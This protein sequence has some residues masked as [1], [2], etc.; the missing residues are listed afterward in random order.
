VAARPIT[1][2]LAV[3]VAGFLV[4]LAA[5]ALA[6]AP[7]GSAVSVMGYT[8]ANGA[9]VTTR[10]PSF[11]IQISGMKPQYFAVWVST[12]SATDGG[13]FVGFNDVIPACVLSYDKSTLT[14]GLNSYDEL[15]PG[16]WYWQ[17]E[18]FDDGCNM[19][20]T[21]NGP[22]TC[23]PGL[24]TTCS[25]DGDC[26]GPA[27]SFTIPSSTGSAHPLVPS[28]PPV[29]TTPASTPVPSVPQPASSPASLPAT[30]V[31]HDLL[32]AP[33][34]PADSSFTGRSIHD[35]TLSRAAYALTKFIHEPRS[36]DVACWSETDWAN[37][38]GGKDSAY[39]TIAF[40]SPTLPHWIN[41]SPQVCRAFNTLLNNRPSYPNVYTAN[42]VE[43][44]THEMMHSI[45]IKNEAAAECFG[46]Q[47]S[48]YLAMNLGVPKAY[49]LG[50][51]KLNLSNYAH[52][53]P[54]YV[55]AVNCREDGRW[56][57]LKDQPSPPWNT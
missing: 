46:M 51:A 19:V 8:P 1:K 43:T 42:A 29:T 30:L 25:Y 20:L 24:G 50:L 39:S 7:A 3:K 13:R 38:E 49:A 36:I 14:C 40:W 31:V 23:Q 2:G 21:F 45:G 47:L 34:L 9:T 35:V 37:I 52:R 26:F 44:L 10:S 5:I 16:T 54:S 27:L 6:F 48:A 18:Y 41:L 28:P 4:F 11:T 57:L 53:P 56:D 15:S 17:W 55:D 32:D 22:A 33:R 12:S